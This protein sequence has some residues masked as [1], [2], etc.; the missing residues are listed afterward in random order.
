MH[1]TLQFPRSLFEVLGR[2]GPEDAQ[3][4][5]LPAACIMGILKEADHDARRTPTHLWPALLVT[6]PL[7]ARATT[8]LNKAACAVWLRTHHPEK[9]SHTDAWASSGRYPRERRSRGGCHILPL[10]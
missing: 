8:F 2:F 4:L 5:S 7:Y 6:H 10:G 3:E 9:K 1:N